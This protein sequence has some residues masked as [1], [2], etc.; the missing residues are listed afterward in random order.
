MSVN[1]SH[2][3]YTFEIIWKVPRLSEK[4]PD[5]L[6]TFQ[7]VWKLSRL[8]GNFPGY[9]ES[10]IIFQKV[11]ALCGMFLN[12]F[13][14]VWSFRWVKRGKRQSEKCCKPGL[15]PKL[16]KTVYYIFLLFG[17]PEILGL[18]WNFVKINVI[19]FH[20]GSFVAKN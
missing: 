6:E 10:S 17:L 12:C 2:S 14:S 11:F 7:I 19:K 4:F 13:E 8:S 20:L 16:F 9:L 3:L 1:F 15:F 18:F 5:C